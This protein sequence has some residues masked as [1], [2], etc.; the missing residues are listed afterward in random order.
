MG[1]V[2]TAVADGVEFYVEVADAGGPANV[3][4]DDVLSFDGV[5]TTVQAIAG[6]LAS[7]WRVVRPDEATVELALAIKVK[8]GKLT[9]LLV[10]GGAEASLK[11]ML[12]WNGA[13]SAAA[14][15]SQDEESEEDQDAEGMAEASPA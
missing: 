1:E 12:K 2:V 10:S 3:G 11:V 7:A 6:E 13:G 8:A 9:G 15:E 4:L 5:R 14:P